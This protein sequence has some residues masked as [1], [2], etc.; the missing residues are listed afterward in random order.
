MSPPAAKE[1]EEDAR[2][3]ESGGV[4][5]RFS[6]S[7]ASEAQRR[8][9]L[10]DVSGACPLGNIGKA[11]F[12]TLDALKQERGDATA[13]ALPDEVD[14]FRGEDEENTRVSM[15]PREAPLSAA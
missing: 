13:L 6:A 14:E 1:D 2:D 9:Q 15:A 5:G 4:A 8:A 10:E 7:V 3:G 11:A 12:D